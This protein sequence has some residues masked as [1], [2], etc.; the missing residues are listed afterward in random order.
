MGIFVVNGALI[1]IILVEIVKTQWM[2][3]PGF[4]IGIF[5]GIYY[6]KDRPQYMNYG[7]LG[8][9]IA[10]EISHIF[11]Q[12]EYGNSKGELRS[13]WSSRSLLNYEEQLQC[14]SN[15]YATFIVPELGHVRISL[16]QP[17]TSKVPLSD[18]GFFVLINCRRHERK[19]RRFSQIT[20][21]Y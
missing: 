15:Q 21:F 9:I 2:V 7:V 11:I 16:A 3:V 17:L 5:R 19:L 8:S 12:A 13:W 1:Q 10:H 14:L 4:P 20:E 18:Y 6:E